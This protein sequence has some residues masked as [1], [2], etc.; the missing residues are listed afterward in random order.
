VVRDGD[1]VVQLRGGVTLSG[2][3]TALWT[4]PAD[5][6][7]V[8]N[9]LPLLCARN[10]DGGSAVAQLQVNANGTMVL[11]APTTGVTGTASSGGGTTGNTAASGTTSQHNGHKHFIFSYNLHP[12]V[13]GMPGGM[14]DVITDALT[15]TNGTHTHT[16]NDGGHTHST[17]NHTHSMTSV[18][19]PTW[20]SFNGIE[21]IL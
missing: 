3:Q 13:S 4:M 11:A 9:L 12:H 15:D 17:P 2:T 7:P 10:P 5:V 20:L 18:A 19:H 1:R 8:V 16:F 14:K 6:R 21:Y